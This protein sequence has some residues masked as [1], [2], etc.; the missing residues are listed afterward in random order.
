[1]AI[2][3]QADADL[4]QV[5]ATSVLRCEP[6]IDFQIASTARLQGLD[7][8]KVLALAV[9]QGRILVTHDW[10]RHASRTQ[11]NAFAICKVYCK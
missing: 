11:D 3:Y 2:C 8:L 5:I 6:A 1:M 7:D 9:Q 10:L 4:N